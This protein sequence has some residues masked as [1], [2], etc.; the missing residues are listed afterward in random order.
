MKITKMRTNTNELPS[1]DTLLKLEK[2]LN[3]KFKQAGFVTNV[4]LG[5][6][7]SNMK[8]GLHM[9]SFTIDPNVCGQ[10]ADVGMVGR[11]CKKGYKTTTIPTWSQREQFNHIVNDCFDKL[12]INAKIVS[13]EYV[14]RDLSGRVN[15]WLATNERAFEIKTLNEVA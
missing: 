6:S 1:T 15:E 3:S 5:E 10:N 4:T 2:M 8:I 12:K 7:R 13:G 14:V 9:K 11:M